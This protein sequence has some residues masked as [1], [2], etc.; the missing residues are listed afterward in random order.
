[1][2][3]KLLF[4]TAL[5]MFSM[6]LNL[7]AQHAHETEKS[8]GGNSWGTQTKEMQT[9][10]TPQ[11][12][13]QKLKDGN[14]RFIE[15][16]MIKRN[17]NMQVKES[18][19]GQYPFAVILSCLDSR[20]SSE[21]I[22]DQGLGDVFNARV[23]GN[24]ENED[25]LGSMEFAC[26]AA[27]AKLVVVLGH[28][29]CGAVKGACDKVEMGNLTNV[30]KQITPA[31]EASKTEGERS[32]KNHEF[33]E[34]VA[35]QNV[36]ATVNDIRQRSAILKEMEQKGEIKLVGGMYNLETGVVEFYNL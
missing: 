5:S 2:K 12:S 8:T 17:Y 20:T 7:S 3:N 6:S 34:A 11:Q 13:L 9:A 22:F 32:S 28:T 1:M 4:V 19:K 36:M 18:A 31:V 24:F 25:I 27:G 33:V 21:I 15:G 29:N 35:K 14:K 26:K 30:I 16:K 10:L 23:A